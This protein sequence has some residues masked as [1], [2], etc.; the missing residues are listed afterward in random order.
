MESS[1]VLVNKIRDL[2]NDL[3]PGQK[4]S[5]ASIEKLLREFQ[6]E[7]MTRQL[8]A[9]SASAFLTRLHAYDRILKW[10][11]MRWA[12]PLMG[13]VKIANMM[14]DLF[15]RAP[16][17]AFLPVEYVKTAAYKW[18]D[19]PDHIPV[20]PRDSKEK[21]TSVLENPSIFQPIALLLVM[22]LLL[23]MSTSEFERAITSTTAN[24]QLPDGFVRH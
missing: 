19:E 1:A 12:T 8:E 17:I 10:F 7:R 18:Q 14:G 11:T 9:S 6:Q 24:L 13:Q 21:L 22:F 20:P 5:K 15:S 4:A 16:K 3:K 2:T 23:F